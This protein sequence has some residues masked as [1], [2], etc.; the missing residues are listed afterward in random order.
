MVFVLAAGF[1][2]CRGT[3]TEDVLLS[4]LDETETGEEDADDA[5]PASEETNQEMVTFAESAEDEALKLHAEEESSEESSSCFVHVCGEV[6]YPGVY[7]LSAGQRIYEAVELAGGFTEFAAG[8]AINLAQEVV[9]GMKVQVPDKEEAAG[10]TAVAPTA[11]AGGVTLPETVFAQA[12][13]SDL[14][15]PE[16]KKVNINTAGSEELMTLNG[17]GEARANAVIQYREEHGGF[18]AI[19]DIMKVPGI[20]DAAFQKIKGNIT[21]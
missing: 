9:D 12:G 13:S 11:A 8:D 7:E 19:E 17:I 2:Y 21:V 1:F 15:S 5:T 6:L 10:W 3:Q 18:Q 14:E 4:A 20:K 16:G